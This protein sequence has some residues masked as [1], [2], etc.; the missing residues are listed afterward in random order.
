M[1][2]YSLF[3]VLLVVDALCPR[4]GHGAVDGR[5]DDGAHHQGDGHDGGHAA[6]EHRQLP[7]GHGL[8]DG[9]ARV[10][11]HR[12]AERRGQVRFLN[13][14]SQEMFVLVAGA[15]TERETDSAVQAGGGRL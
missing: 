7:P 4:E 9:A 2:V 6:Q 12:Q 5:G 15:S 10:R 8:H 1:Y 14:Q 11:G 13:V 3:D